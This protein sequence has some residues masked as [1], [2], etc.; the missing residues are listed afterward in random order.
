MK[1]RVYNP[2]TKKWEILASPLPGDLIATNTEGYKPNEDGSPLSIQDCLTQN[3]TDINTLKRDVKYIYENGTIGGG[4]G[5]GGGGVFPTIELAVPDTVIVKTDNPFTIAFFFNSPNPGDGTANFVI[6]KKASLEP[7]IVDVRK[8]IKQGR[9]GYTFDPIPPGNY[10]LTISA[11]DNLGVGSNPIS[12]SVVC[13]ALELSTPDEL[14]RDVSITEDVIVRYTIKSIFTEELDLHITHLDGRFETIK[15]RPGTYEMNLGRIDSLGV[16][17]FKLKAQFNDT[18]S[19][20]LNFNFIVTDSS[21]MFMS[22]TFEGGEFR[23][24]AGVT[25]N[26][27]ISLLGA[28]QFL[29][30][31][32][33]DGNIFETNVE[34]KIGHN[35]YSFQNL[36]LGPHQVTFKSRTLE[37]VNPIR[38]ELTVPVFTIVE[39]TG[40]TYQF[41]RDGLVVS[42]DAR[43]GKSN[44]QDQARRT[45]WEDT[46]PGVPTRTRLHHF[47][48]NHINGWI[49]NSAEDQTV[50]ALTFAGQSYAEIDLQPLNGDILNGITVEILHNS[51]DTGNPVQNV[52]N[53]I[54][55]LFDGSKGDGKG[56]LVDVKEAYMRTSYA[57]SLN[58]EFNSNEWVK[59]TFVVNRKLNQIYIYTNGAMSGYAKIDSAANFLLNKKII[60]GARKNAAGEIVDNANCKIKTFRLYNRVLNDEEVFKNAVADLP[61]AEQEVIIDLHEGQSIIPTMKLKFD[62]GALNSAQSITP[63]DIEYSDPSDPSKSIILYNSMI[64]K[65]GTT[66][67]TYPVSNYTLNLY[68]AG[69][70]YDW[71]PKDSFMPENIYTLKADFMDSSHANNTGIARFASDM[72]NRLG[73]KNPAQ[74]M[75]DRVKNTIDGFVI[76]LY[77]NG[78]HRGLYNL[79]SDRYGHKNY[80]LNLPKFK[81]V[82]VSYEAS[83][84]TGVATGFHTTE[85]DKVRGAF[86]VR[87]FKGES[88]EKKYMTFDPETQ[89]MVMSQGVHREFERLIQWINDAGNDPGERFYMEMKDHLDVNHTLLYLLTVEIFGLMDNL[90]KNMVL[91]FFG[92]E[93]DSSTGA[94]VEKWY[95]QLYDLDSSVGLSNNGDLKYQPCVNFTQEPGMPADHQ[96]NGTTSLLWTSVKKF[97]AKELKD[98]YAQLRRQGILNLTAM[99]KHYQGETIDKVSP[100]FYSLDSRLKYISPSENGTNKETYYKFAKGRRIEFTR[101][102]LAQRIQFLDSVYEYGNE[103]NPDGDY[104]KYIQ[105]RY[106]K[107]NMEATHFHISVKSKSP[108]FLTTVDDS[109]LPHGRKYFVNSDKYYDVEIPINA[110][111]DGAMFGITFGP[112]L[113]DIKF[114]EDIRLTSLYLEH[115][116]SL[117]E[118]NISKNPDLTSIVLDNCPSLQTFDVNGCVKLGSETGKETLKFDN[119]PNI[120]YIDF[121]NTKIAGFTTHPEGGVIEV[122]KCDDSKIETFVIKK[123][124][125]ID[126]LNI[127][128]CS[129][130]KKVEI[131]KCNLIREINFPSSV[132]ATFRVLDCP[133]ITNVVMC[134]TPFLNS[135]VDPTDPERR[136]HF[137]IDNCPSLTRI[138]MSGL[139]HKDMTSLDLINIEKIEYLDVSRCGFLSE[140]RFS[141]AAT[142]LS[143]FKCNDTSIK[144]FKIGRAGTTVDYLDLGIFRKLGNVNFENCRNLR[145]V[146]NCNIGRETPAPGTSIFRSCDKLTRITGYLRLTGNIN[147]AWAG[148]TVL[149]NLPTDLDLSGCTDSARAFQS[150]VAL[151]M[152]EAVRIMSKLTNLQYTWRM[153]EGCTGLITNAS[154]P[155]PA[156]FFRYNSK[157][158]NVDIMFSGCTNLTGDFPN[159]LYSFLPE[160]VMIR[161]PFSGCNFT[162]PIYAADTMLNTNTK[163]QTLDNPFANCRFTRMPD[164]RFLERCTD[165]RSII[166]LFSGQGGMTKA[167]DAGQNFVSADY[168]INNPLIS[169]MYGVFNSC[170]GLIG[171]IPTGLFRNQRHIEDIRYI[172]SNCGGITGRFPADFFPKNI[173]NGVTR[174]K[175]RLCSYAFYNCSGITGKIPEDLFG[176]HDNVVELAYTFRGCTGIGSQVDSA[177]DEVFPKRIFRNKR[178]L[179]T[180]EG[181]FQN[182]YNF[183]VG[184]SAH[185][186][187][188]KDLFK[189]AVNINNIAYAFDNC[190]MLYGTLPG[191]FFNVKD[192]D[193]EYMPNKITRAEAVFRDCHTISGRIPQNFFKSFFEV[194]NLNE[195]F[196]RCY[197]LIGGIP[198]SLFYNCVKLKS[199]RYF[200]HFPWD[201]T[202]RKIGTD[203]DN[204]EE[205]Y[206]D[207][208]T[209]YQYIFNKDIFM[210]CPNLED[211]TAFLYSAGGQMAGRLPTSMWTSN[212]ELKF[213]DLMFTNTGV[214]GEVNRE[215]FG[216]TPKLTGF[217][218]FLW[219]TGTFTSITSDCIRADFHNYV[220]RDGNGNIV[221]KNFGGMF[222]GNGAMTGTV[223]RLWEMY[224]DAISSV[225]QAGGCFAGC[226]A[227]ANYAD[228]P[229]TWK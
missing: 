133:I 28:R 68:D 75:D 183:K 212:R 10:E 11:I 147:E 100:Y 123:Q 154:S 192:P 166:N 114:S 226:T 89:Q 3:R 85:W 111:A 173:E 72:F 185:D 40:R 117:V 217:S 171:T 149:T 86:K 5:G 6:T 104:W 9:N 103:N 22:S 150:C 144:N 33:L 37:S 12:M 29:T 211:L 101:R 187:A 179:S 223:P 209:G 13:G 110:A 43:R 167:Q 52:H 214:N 56:F 199:L 206:I 145:E 228:I 161:Y 218:N 87:Y 129:A 42:L 19:N 35:F 124:H 74:M 208:A 220:H 151:N 229:P 170:G 172:L 18:E 153:F 190:R 219:A 102:W 140:V 83:S 69:I 157:I 8:S 152:T 204:T 122:L 175:L 98:K 181:I 196:C 92:E 186:Q 139:A 180:I 113:M 55:D 160:L 184:F 195:F 127:R 165:L 16:K 138:E 78:V 66:S 91:T 88:D 36:P 148:C 189:E 49:P 188:D 162:I 82:G 63:V 67:L 7:P 61:G 50:E 93:F 176:D 99:M 76:N 44:T 205:R 134:N 25:I 90:E 224:P 109:M 193:G 59:H 126:S 164:K 31:V 58:S 4:G 64:K 80:G 97:F 216:S 141:E 119:C 46:E 23:K 30:D 77:V 146:R 53:V 106:L 60:L 210:Y 70:P 120:K 169:N 174:S 45:V 136:T 130:L 27:R 26:Y 163:L 227:V 41:S 115:A 84:N 191:D 131:E 177:A 105:A 81:S 38:A 24:D 125:Y 15:K 182:C 65:Q 48:F 202:T 2:V 96:Y 137:L 215:L 201:G 159:T 47:A 95:P 32:Y 14:S 178:S 79:N 225:G 107:R 51:Y 197:Q 155:F 203:R 116:K 17:T 94:M 73:V 198:Y 143:T 213:I 142:N 54:L 20:T 132:I 128:N 62:E 194:Q 71:A 135:L 222:S 39:N 156:D 34:S 21:S 221:K 112:Q 200:L 207:E 108:L 57:D 1:F 121:S 168:F 118:L 158:R